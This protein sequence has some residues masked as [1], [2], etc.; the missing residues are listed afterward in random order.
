VKR[1]WKEVAV[2]HA[3][4]GWRVLLDGRPIRTQ[5]GTAQLL[6][7]RGLA[8]MLADEWRAQEEEIGPAGF[9]SRDMA[10]YAIDQVAPD[11]A[12]TVAKLLGYAETDTLCYRADPDEPLHRRQW[13][14][15]EP[16]L[17]AF[18]AREG[19]KMERVSG[20]VHRPQRAETLDTLRARLEREN[21]FTL[22]ALEAMASLAASL[23]IALTAIKPDAD[24]AALW[25]AAELEEQWQAD[26][27]GREQEAEERRAKRERDFLRAVEF[28]KR[29]GKR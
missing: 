29:A 14:V 23:C 2:E 16:L 7:T 27:W 18:E 6:P 24:P 4:G 11:P 3:G 9:A 10:D 25:A 1:F 8:E 15:W 12:A 13:E 20:I 5:A 28:A 22:A 26:L 17:A 21:A 19:V